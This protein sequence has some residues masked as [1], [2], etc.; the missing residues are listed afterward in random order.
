V[1][2]TAGDQVPL[3]PFVEVLGSVNVPP[4]QMGAI[5]LKDGVVAGFT[6]TVRVAVVAQAPAAGEKV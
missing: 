4:A 6:V 3:I 2:F 1:L 5:G